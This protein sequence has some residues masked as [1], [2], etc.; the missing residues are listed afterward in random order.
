[1]IR[2]VAYDPRWPSRYEAEAAAIRAAFGVL[3]HRVDHVGS[4]SVPGLEAKPVIDIQVS[5][6][7][8]ESLEPFKPIMQ[9]CG[10]RHFRD[11]DPVFERAYPYFHKPHEW[12]HS[13]HVHL[14]EAGSEWEWK[15][16]AFRDYL[17]WHADAREE[18]VALK[19][20][21]A[22]IHG[23]ANHGERQAYADAKGEFV[24]RILEAARAGRS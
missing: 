14:C 6:A 3:A 5:V 8:L 17:R 9:S 18:Y 2:L 12:P 24:Q 7:S 10:Y 1:M 11:P 21:L 20:Q 16:L 4:T 22:A 23:G 13:H 15:H 19:R